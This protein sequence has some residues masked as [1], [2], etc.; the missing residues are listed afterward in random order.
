MK[1]T[2]FKTFVTV[3]GDSNTKAFYFRYADQ[4]SVPDEVL[5][6]GNKLTS[7]KVINV[8]THVLQG[9]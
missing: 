6:E 2:L 7:E 3:L 8:D 5:V 1:S 9:E 4:V